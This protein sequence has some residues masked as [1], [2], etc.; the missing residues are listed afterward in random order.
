MKTIK[1]YCLITFSIF[2]MAVGVYFFKFPNNFCFGGIT[3]FAVVIAKIMPISASM[4]TFCVNMI[5]LLVGWIF[6]GKSFAIKTGYASIL[7]SLLLLVFEKVYP[8]HIPLSNEPTLELIFAIT[9]PAIGS[10]LLFNIGASSGGTDVLAM[11]LQKYTRV[12]IG[13]ALLVTDMIAILIAC[14]VFDIKTAL[15]SFVG[16]TLKSF[17]IDGIIENINMCKAFTIICDNPDSICDY[18]VHDLNRSATVSE[19]SGAYT[20]QEKFMVVTVLTR[21]QAVQLRQYIHQNEPGA[22]ILIYNT[23]E[24]VGKGFVTI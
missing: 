17:L 9:L 18:I 19:A 10:A 6:L 5:L 23:S 4:F 21:A 11:L 7:L 14:F 22:F 16:L 15:Y 2:I 13:M 8:M 3:G 24:I 1:N 12:H 20:N